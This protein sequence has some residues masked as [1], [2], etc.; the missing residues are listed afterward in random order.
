VSASAEWRA[1]V[2]PKIERAMSKFEDATDEELVDVLI[3]HYFP[4][5]YKWPSIERRW[6]REAIEELRGTATPLKVRLPREPIATGEDA[7]AAYTEHRSER[8]AARAL[9]VSRTQL[10]RLLGKQT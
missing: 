4:P 1:A 8:K 9:G 10:R 2:D 7:A 3:A 5:T 6:L